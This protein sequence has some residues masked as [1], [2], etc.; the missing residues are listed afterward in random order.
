MTRFVIALPLILSLSASLS[1]AQPASQTP[2]SKP[3]ASASAPTPAKPA[4]TKPYITVNGYPIPQYIVDIFIADQKARGVDTNSPDFQKA[5]REEMIRR[6]ALLS[7]AKKRAL[8]KK[9]EYKRQLEI[10]S[11]IILMRNV[12]ADHLSQNPISDEE[13]QSTYNA[14]IVQMG[15]S[16]YKLRHIQLKTEADAKAIIDKLKDGKKFEKLVKESTDDTTKDKGGDLGWKTPMTLPPAVIGA[17]RSL[18]KGD[19]TKTPIHLGAVWHVFQL[20]DLRPLNPPS[21]D[22]LKPGLAQSLIQIKTTQYIESL[23]SKAEAK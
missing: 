10:A 21:L 15:N 23:K 12:V 13:I 17:V 8:E 14:V 18:K 5:V 1:H 16:E 11:H 3:P 9:P 22:E 7:E 6:G 4:S 2:P 19:F 20:E